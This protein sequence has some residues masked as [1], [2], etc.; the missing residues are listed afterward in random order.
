MRQ[1]ITVAVIASCLPALAGCMDGPFY[2]MK[3]MN[4][5]FQANWRADREFGPTFEDRMTELKLLESQVASMPAEEQAEWA[6]RLEKL[7]RD[8]ASPE[9][10]SRAILVAAQLPGE[11]AERTL[12]IASADKVEKVRLTAC[13]AWQRRGGNAARDMLLSLAVADD[14]NSVRQSAIDQLAVFN[15]PE[16][17]RSLSSLLEDKSPAVQYQVAESLAALTGEDYGG[18][19]DGWKQY[20]AALTPNLD[21]GSSASK[22]LPASGSS[23]LPQSP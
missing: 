15:E 17:L 10:R 14:S 2:A 4:P 23:V 8:D 13:K 21:D 5:V 22:V 7:V 9:I 6:I 3:R 19:I 12:N 18:D 16:V 20:M 1:Q 11:A